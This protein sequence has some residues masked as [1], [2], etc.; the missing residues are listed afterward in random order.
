MHIFWSIVLETLLLLLGA[1]TIVVRANLKYGTFVRRTFTTR[2]LNCG[3]VLRRIFTA[4]KA[5]VGIPPKPTFLTMPGELR[6]KIY[7][8]VLLSE[9]ITI[10]KGRSAKPALFSTCRQIYQETTAIFYLENYWTI[11]VYDWDLSVYEA[12]H[13]QVRMEHGIPEELT[14]INI[15]TGSYWKKGN[16]IKLLQRLHKDQLTYGDY[17]YAAEQDDKEAII[18]GAFYIVGCLHKHSWHDIEQVL[19][20]YLNEAVGGIDGCEWEDE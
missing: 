6:N 4:R 8:L 17:V 20:I 3:A 11:D 7:R 15:N 13:D 2:N 1:L 14:S 9:S 10:S 19:Q 12:F 5:V 18:H 16:L